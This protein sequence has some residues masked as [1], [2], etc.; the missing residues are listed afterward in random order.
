MARTPQEEFWAGGSSEPG[1]TP[2][3]PDL[4]LAEARRLMGLAL[5]L[6]KGVGDAM[7]VGAGS[8]RHLLLVKEFIPLAEA[9]AMEINEAAEQRLRDLGISTYLGSILEGPVPGGRYDLVL[10]MG[11]LAC[12]PPEGLSEALTQLHAASDR[13]LLLR[14]YSGPYA[15]FPHGVTTIYRREYARSLPDLFPDL[16]LLLDV[17][18]DVRGDLEIRWLLF[19]RDGPK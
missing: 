1:R 6:T 17:P 9:Y 8:G 10:A 2:T 15:E 18:E 14:E 5:S 3:P 19:E 16:R 4:G 11:L 12:V 7:D 13:Y